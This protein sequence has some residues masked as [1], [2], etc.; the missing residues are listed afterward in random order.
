MWKKSFFDKKEDATIFRKG[1]TAKQSKVLNFLVNEDNN[2]DRIKEFTGDSGNLDYTLM[3]KHLTVTAPTIRKLRKEIRT[4][5]GFREK[6]KFIES[7]ERLHSEHWVE[8]KRGYIQQYE[9]IKIELGESLRGF[10]STMAKARKLQTTADNIVKHEDG[11]SRDLLHYIEFNKLSDDEF[12]QVGT[13]LKQS[14][15]ERRKSCDAN[16]AIKELINGNTITEDDFKSIQRI[17]AKIDNYKPHYEHNSNRTYN[18]N[19][20]DLE[21]NNG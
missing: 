3:A 14:R 10:I 4:I 18:Y 20:I 9:A 19:F 6:E 1:R 12:I 16:S 17:L 15:A 5:L 7:E 11:V 13:T 21:Q 8:D 2:E